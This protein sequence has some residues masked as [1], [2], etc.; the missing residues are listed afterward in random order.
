MLWLSD[1]DS[2]VETSY[3]Q[4]RLTRDSLHSQTSVGRFDLLI[5]SYGFSFHHRGP[6]L[7]LNSIG[8]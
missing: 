2:A 4:P 6:Y 7:R 8:L 3:S 1:V 5:D